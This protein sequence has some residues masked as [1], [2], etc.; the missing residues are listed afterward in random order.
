MAG[1]PRKI[2]DD[3][4]GAAILVRRLI[5]EQASAHWRRYLT[6]FVLMGIAAGAT[7][8]SAYILGQAINQ[9]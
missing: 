1:F 3:P 9:A 8:L 2:T 7:A 6:A 4:H 5:T